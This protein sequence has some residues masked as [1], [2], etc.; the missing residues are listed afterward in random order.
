MKILVKLFYKYR[1]NLLLNSIYILLLL[2]A[3]IIGIKLSLNIGDKEIYIL[4]TDLILFIVSLWSLILVFVKITRILD[5][6]REKILKK[7][8]YKYIN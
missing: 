5:P 4:K 8:E 6:F 2:I 1:H 7:A 3:G